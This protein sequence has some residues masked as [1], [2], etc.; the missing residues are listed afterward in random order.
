MGKTQKIFGIG[1]LVFMDCIPP[2]LGAALNLDREVS[3][4]NKT[5]RMTNVEALLIPQCLI[6]EWALQNSLLLSE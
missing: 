4:T 6:K 2:A 5:C 1:G 3:A